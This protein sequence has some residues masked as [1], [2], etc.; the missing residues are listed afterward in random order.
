MANSP[1]L[2]ATPTARPHPHTH[3]NSSSLA[4]T[5]THAADLHMDRQRNFLSPC[6]CP[7][8]KEGIHIQQMIGRG[9]SRSDLFCFPSQW[10]KVV[11]I[12]TLP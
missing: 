4:D 12:M 9:R 1:S 3:T 8:G 2:Q 5:H 11:A 10:Q 6:A 7:E